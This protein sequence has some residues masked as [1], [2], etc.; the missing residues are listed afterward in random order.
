MEVGQPDTLGQKYVCILGEG[1]QINFVC[2]FLIS[3]ISST[4]LRVLK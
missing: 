1:N 3:P 2:L 4:K